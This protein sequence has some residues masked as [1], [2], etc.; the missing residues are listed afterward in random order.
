MGNSGKSAIKIY[1]NEGLNGKT[2]YIWRFLWENM[3][4]PSISGGS[5]MG[6][7]SLNQCWVFRGN[8]LGF[9]MGI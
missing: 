4:K 7:S 5:L 1:R 6:T 3:G 2:M 9:F 8:D